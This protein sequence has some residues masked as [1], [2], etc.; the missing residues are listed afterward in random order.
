MNA[1]I[2]DNLAKII[3][4]VFS[5]Y[6]INMFAPIILILFVNGQ[7]MSSIFYIELWYLFDVALPGLYIV[8]IQ[9]R[10][11]ISDLHIQ[12]K[13]NRLLPMLMIVLCSALLVIIYQYIDAPKL[14]IIS[15]F[16]FFVNTIVILS[17][18]IFWKISIH[19]AAYSGIISIL[20]L[21]ISGQAFWL[22]LLIPLI[23][24]ARVRRK[25]HT[26]WQGIWGGFVP[27]VITY[28]ILLVV[29]P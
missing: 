10:K 23:I 15:A 3:S 22:M 9:G 28:L 4:I 18:T 13:D 16:V 27:F 5:P 8:R 24:W 12:N 29:S 11:F 1:K 20:G 14:I 19:I 6:L 21:V 7:N 26:V 17:I 2:F 25:R